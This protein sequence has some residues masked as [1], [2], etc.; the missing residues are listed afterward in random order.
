MKLSSFR[1][2]EKILYKLTVILLLSSSIIFHNGCLSKRLKEYNK[3]YTQPTTEINTNILFLPGHKL[4]DSYAF[5]SSFGHKHFQFTGLLKEKNKERT[6]SIYLPISDEIGLPVI[7]EAANGNASS[8][9]EDAYLYV[10]RHAEKIIADSHLK[11][12]DIVILNHVRAGNPALTV[13]FIAHDCDV[14]AD[15]GCRKEWKIKP[16]F[17]WVQRKKLTILASRS[18]YGITV[19]FDVVYTSFKGW[20]YALFRDGYVH[21]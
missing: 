2:S 12:K 1:L 10:N 19:P 18:L 5:E 3:S 4:S 21:N 14:S 13:E 6:V 17:N 7:V 15:A 20:I 16:E 8:N 11:Q 9:S